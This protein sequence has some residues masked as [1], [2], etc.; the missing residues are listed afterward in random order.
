MWG[1]EMGFN[2]NGVA[3]ANE[4]IFTKR[5]F[6]KQGLLGMDLLRLGL[7]AGNDAKC[8]LNTMVDFVEKY[9]QG[10]SNSIFKEEY[11]DNSFLICD[12][13]EAYILETYGSKWRSQ[14]ISAF[15]SISNSPLEGTSGQFNYSLNRIYNYFGKGKSRARITYSMLQE[16]NGSLKVEGLMQIMHHHSEIEFHPNKGTNTDICMHSGSLTRKF[17]TAN[18]MILELHDGCDIAWFTFSSNPCISLYK[19]VLFGCGEVRIDYGED[20]WYRAERLHRKVAE[21]DQGWYSRAM[22]VT[23]DNQK[24][25]NQLVGQAGEITKKK[26]EEIYEKVMMIDEEHIN[27]I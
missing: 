19:P 1:A 20:Y 17:Q 3:I 15:G 22:N 9:G 4:A 2:E 12:R 10:G 11:Y 21:Y 13:N 26:A 14:R 23:L 24:R 25:V 6:A 16:M 27:S 8:A 18:S 5:K 7:E